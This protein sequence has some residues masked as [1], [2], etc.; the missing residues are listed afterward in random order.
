MAI[1][2]IVTGDKIIDTNIIKAEEFVCLKHAY[3]GN[4]KRLLLTRSYI[5]LN[6]YRLYFI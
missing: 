1:I 6:C 5:I 2:I 3:L 4:L